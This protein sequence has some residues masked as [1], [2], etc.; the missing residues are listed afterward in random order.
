MIMMLAR[1]TGRSNM[2]DYLRLFMSMACLGMM[3]LAQAADDMASP[4]EGAPS[5][6]L[7][8]VYIGT[9]DYPLENEEAAKKAGITLGAY[10]L[11]AP[12]N[13]ERRLVMALPAD[14]A[15]A[16]TLVRQRF[17]ALPAEEVRA[18]FK[19][20]VMASQWDIRKAPAFVFG[21]GEAVIYGLTDVGEALGHWE[22]WR[23]EGYR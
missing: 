5:P 17:G 12:R 7:Q 14:R 19:A 22:A 2:H 15:T 4:M 23:R 1:L 21:G 20:V 9:N 10:N 6:A 8:V 3:S 18:I 11:D 13:L 16:E